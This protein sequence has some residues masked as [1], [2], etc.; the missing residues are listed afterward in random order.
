MRTAAAPAM[1]FELYFKDK[2]KKG[3]KQ[4]FLIP[5]RRA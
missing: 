4:C 3:E 5:T 1:D 2:E